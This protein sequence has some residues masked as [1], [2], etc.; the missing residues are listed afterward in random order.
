MKQLYVLL[1]LSIIAG[2]CA[3]APKTGEQQAQAVVSEPA[4]PATA[5]PSPSA[6]LKPSD[7]PQPTSTATETPTITPTPTITLTPTP[8]ATPFGGG[9]GEVSMM[10]NVNVVKVSLEDTSDYDI[11]VPYDKIMALLKIDQLSTL[12]S[13]SVS[14]NGDLVAFW[15]CAQE[16]CDTKRG[17]LYLFSTNFNQKVAIDVPGLP[18]FMGWSPDQS[19][20]LYYLGS[21]MSD[22]YY[23]VKTKDPGFGEVIKL[24]RLV[25]VAWAPDGQTI[26]A[27][28][29]GTVYQYDLDGNELNTWACNFNNACMHALSPDGKRFAG[30]Q[31]YVPTNQGNPTIFISNPD[32]TDKKTIRISEDK[33]LI[34][35]LAWL[36]DNRHVV[37]V[38]ESAKQRNRRFWRLDY[39]SILDVDTGEERNIDLKIADDVENFSFCGLTPDGM[40]AVFVAVGGRVKEQGRVL[41]SGRAAM[42]YPLWVDDAELVR[43][44]GFEDVWESCPTWLVK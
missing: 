29:G 37:L 42:L 21:S 17:V 8:V 16:Y 4:Q 35:Y 40:H 12:R 39:L 18:V 19:R 26:Y 11:V 33:A 30:I 2:G 5:L 44:T 7:T 20:L 1:I 9:N 31:K 28:K 15:N 6:T 13:D 14:P 38:G 41:M 32:F 34:L 10:V 25:D 43:L 36:P 3:T 23:L 24:G 27:Q 22:D